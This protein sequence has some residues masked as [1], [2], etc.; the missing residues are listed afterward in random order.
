MKNANADEHIS[1]KKREK[2]EISSKDKH[3]TIQEKKGPLT[4]IHK[5]IEGKEKANEVQSSEKVQETTQDRN[6]NEQNMMIENVGRD[7]VDKRNKPAFYRRL[8]RTWMLTC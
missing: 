7:V 1:K 5:Q 2:D 6:E 3:Y 8:F 4:E